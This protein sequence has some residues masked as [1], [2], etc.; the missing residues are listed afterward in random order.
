MFVGDSPSDLAALVAADV[1]IVVGGNKLLRRVAAAAGV[2]LQPL[3]TG[4]PPV[5]PSHCH[6]LPPPPDPRGDL[7]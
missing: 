3:V 7:K 2:R 5:C 1:G 4:A 6:P